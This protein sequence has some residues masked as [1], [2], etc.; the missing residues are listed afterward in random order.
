[1]RRRERE[2]PAPTP[3]PGRQ[4]LSLMWSLMSAAANFQSVPVRRPTLH[5]AHFI[6]S[7]TWVAY[8]AY[9][10]QGSAP[11]RHVFC[12]RGPQSSDVALRPPAGSVRRLMNLGDQASSAAKSQ[13]PDATLA[14]FVRTWTQRTHGD[15]TVMGV[16]CMTMHALRVVPDFVMR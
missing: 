1:M 3:T 5:G 11:H 4:S 13:S 14:L 15:R 2:A 10:I 6:W 16:A 7:S 8:V 12:R 9:I